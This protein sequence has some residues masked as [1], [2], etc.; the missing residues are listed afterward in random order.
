MMASAGTASTASPC[1]FCR[2]SWPTWAGVSR[3]TV[4]R[5]TSPSSWV[6]SLAW[7][8][9]AVS[10]PPSTATRTSSRRLLPDAQPVQEPAVERGLKRLDPGDRIL[11]AHEL[12]RSLVEVLRLEVE[13]GVPDTP[14]QVTV[15]LGYLLL[16][17]AL[18]LLLL[19]PTRLDREQRVDGV[20]R[21]LQRHPP[22]DDC[23]ERPV[24]EAHVHVDSDEVLGAPQVLRPAGRV[25]ERLLEQAHHLVRPDEV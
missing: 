20:V 11:L 22:L 17:L 16:D 7:P 1:G 23:P 14:K 2:R 13:H 6:S 12:D 4:A 24:P 3:T 9:C 10:R 25:R 8:L 15:R 5:S 21:Q 18:R 19:H